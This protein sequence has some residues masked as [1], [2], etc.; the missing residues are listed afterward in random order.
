MAIEIDLKELFFYIVIGVVVVGGIWV[1]IYIEDKPQ[2][3]DPDEVC[4]RLEGYMIYDYYNVDGYANEV[5][6]ISF[7]PDLLDY[8]ETLKDEFNITRNPEYL[9][10]EAVTWTPEEDLINCEVNLRICMDDNS[11]LCN[12]GYVAPITVER[13]LF[14]NWYNNMTGIHV[15]RDE[16]V[17]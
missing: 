14:V 10:G 7:Y 1:V 8:I 2:N 3:L 17:F 16:H 13:D 12:D 4:E 6:E 9:M 5:L 11:N 15:R